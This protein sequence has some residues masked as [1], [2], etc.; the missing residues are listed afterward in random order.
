[1]T[2]QLFPRPP[3]RMKQPR[4]DALR[5]ALAQ[6]TAEVIRRREEAEALQNQLAGMAAA[7]A[8]DHNTARRVPRWIR[9]LFGA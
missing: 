1:M 7:R 9:A 4:K 6:T 5:D 3:R 2:D 8:H